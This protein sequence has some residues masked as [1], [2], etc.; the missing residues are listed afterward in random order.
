MERLNYIDS[1]KAF[2]SYKF[3]GH[4][5]ALALTLVQRRILKVADRIIIWRRAGLNT[6]GPKHALFALI[7][8]K[9]DLQQEAI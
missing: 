1:N 4:K 6:L 8:V 3:A 5:Q 2:A 9:R 7:A